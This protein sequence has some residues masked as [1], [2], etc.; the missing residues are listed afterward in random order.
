[1]K[2]EK[3]KLPVI[4]ESSDNYS[5]DDFRIKLGKKGNHNSSEISTP[6]NEDNLVSHTFDSSDND[7]SDSKGGKGEES[8]DL[9]AVINNADNSSEI[10]TK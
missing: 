7:T 2:S 1:M 10:R 9:S 8:L 5:D 3:R 6:S 4:T